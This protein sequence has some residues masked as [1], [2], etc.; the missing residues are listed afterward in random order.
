MTTALRTPEQRVVLHNITWE[1]Y[2]SL[3]C[4]HLDCSVPRFTYDRGELEIV[5][6]SG[7][8]EELIDVVVS[9]VKIVAEQMGINVK[10]YGSTTFRLK[11]RKRGFE[12][13]ACFYI[14]NLN[15]I[16]GKKDLDLRVDPPPDLAIEI[17]ITRSSL[18]K[19]SIMA[20]AGVPEVWHYGKNG[21]RILGLHEG[22]Y[23]ERE[24]SIALPV[25]TPADIVR[26]VD[27]SDTVE[28]LIWTRR[29]RDWVS[30]SR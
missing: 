13:D 19:F 24:S 7:A 29:I 6:P 12:P 20:E 8:H 28:P 25:L 27:E 2:E 21:W 18:N 17:D 10:G 16:L 11:P 22:H 3:L 5:C 4:V 9:L 1:L 30:S 15:R 26:L 14:A 23:Q